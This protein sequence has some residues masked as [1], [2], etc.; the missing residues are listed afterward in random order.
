[1]KGWKHLET[2]D[3]L[4]QIIADSHKQTVVVFKHS[5]R[6]SISSMAQR[7]LAD[8]NTEHAAQAAF[9]YLD[10]I[11]HRDVSNQIADRLNEIHQS[12]Q[13]LVLKNGECVYEA[14][15]MEISSRELQELL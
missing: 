11:A 14:S 5:T 3:Q 8:L 10:L 2:I 13:I 4:D 1:M 7:R 6:C 9:Y 15:H 12:P